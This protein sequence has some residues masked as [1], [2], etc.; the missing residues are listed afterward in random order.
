MALVKSKENAT[1]FAHA[2]HSAS[3]LLCPS[4]KTGQSREVSDAPH[5]NA[6]HWR[7][8]TLTDAA[9]LTSDRLSRTPH[10]RS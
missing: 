1:R 5:P 2:G 6:N 4:A 10:D 3:E 8:P 9:T 7:Q